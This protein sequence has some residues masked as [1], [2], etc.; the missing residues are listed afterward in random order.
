MKM[1]RFL[2]CAVALL[3]KYNVEPLLFIFM[4]TGTLYDPTVALSLITD[5]VCFNDFKKD[6]DFCKQINSKEFKDT[7]QAKDIQATAVN[8]VMYGQII[9]SVPAIFA[10]IFLGIFNKLN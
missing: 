9:H 10:A 2:A 8:Y 5:K 6:S 1:S 4:F 7:Q 3:R